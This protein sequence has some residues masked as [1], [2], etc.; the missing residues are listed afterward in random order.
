[1]ELSVTELRQGTK[2]FFTG[3]VRDITER[4]QAE[5]ELRRAR[6]ELEVRVEERTHEL[7]QEIVERHR[8]EDSL[9]LAGEVIESLAEGVAIINPDFRISS[10][11]P[12]YAAICGYEMQQD[13]KSVV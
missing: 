6:D 4:K 12:A 11:N 3:I 7:T 8:A 10:V 9:R 13:R 1:M 5:D 2:R